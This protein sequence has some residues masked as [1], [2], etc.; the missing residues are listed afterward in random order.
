[1]N[2]LRF[3]IPQL[4][5]PLFLSGIS[6]PN[7]KSYKLGYDSN[8]IYITHY[9]DEVRHQVE[10]TEKVGHAEGKPPPTAHLKKTISLTTHES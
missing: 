5:K 2:S 4:L 9:R 8:V 6:F 3:F 1:M 7:Y 10:W